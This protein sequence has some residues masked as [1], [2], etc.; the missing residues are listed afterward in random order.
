MREN[1][2]L[3]LCLLLASCTLQAIIVTDSLP[4]IIKIN[5]NQYIISIESPSTL[6][7]PS[8]QQS[9]IKQS[10]VTQESTSTS[11]VATSSADSQLQN[12]LSSLSSGPIRI[13][14]S[15]PSST[16]IAADSST[17]FD[18]TQPQQNSADSSVKPTAVAQRP[19]NI[20]IPNPVVSAPPVMFTPRVGLSNLVSSPTITTAVSSS[21][22]PVIGLANPTSASK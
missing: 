6:S 20:G 18:T 2:S 21:S 10:T 22:G 17:L 16:A 14:S 15:G 4:S 11:K 1:Y 13:A 3:L 7:D 9:T 19:L 8:H 5:S 12:I